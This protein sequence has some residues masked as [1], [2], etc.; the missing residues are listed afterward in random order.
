MNKNPE[1]ARVSSLWPR[2]PVFPVLVLV[3]AVL[4]GQLAAPCRS[5][6]ST[7]VSGTIRVANGTTLLLIGVKWHTVFKGLECLCVFMN[8]E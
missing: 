6:V 8:H 3:T 1:M 4:A 2:K 5:S 7:P